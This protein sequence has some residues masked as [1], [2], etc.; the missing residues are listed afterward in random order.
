[1]PPSDSIVSLE[2]LESF[3]HKRMETP[4]SLDFVTEIL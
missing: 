1:M 4:N 3:E 2:P